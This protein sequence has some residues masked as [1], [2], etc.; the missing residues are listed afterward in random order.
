MMREA[1]K[2]FFNLRLE[3]GTIV[4]IS[5]TLHDQLEAARKEYY[6]TQITLGMDEGAVAKC[7]EIGV[8]YATT[9]AWKSNLRDAQR[10]AKAAKR[11]YDETLAAYRDFQDA[12]DKREVAE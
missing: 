2:K 4:H 6:K 10:K 8:D 7:D 9:S 12:N 1:L 5:G 3:F 11:K